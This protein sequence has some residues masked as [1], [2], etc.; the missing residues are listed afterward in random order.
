MIR[1]PPIPNMAAISE[2]ILPNMVPSTMNITADAMIRIPKSKK[3]FPLFI[4]I[5]SSFE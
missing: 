4:E 3:A 2:V 5:N 1:I